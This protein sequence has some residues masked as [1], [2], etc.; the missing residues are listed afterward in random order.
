M[1]RRAML[2]GTIVA[3]W[4]AGLAVLVRR[5]YFRP[6]VE[7]LAEAALRVSPGAVFF[8]VMQ[9][10]QQV[11]FASSTIDTTDGA[12]SVVDY[13]VARTSAGGQTRRVSERTS[14]TLS[15]ALRIRKFELAR[16]ADGRPTRRGGRVE[17]DSVLIFG[18]EVGTEKVDSQHVALS[19]P[20]LLPTLV[21]LAV[22]LGERPKVGKRY[23][24][25]VL[26]PSSM[27]P[28]NVTLRIRAESL[29][30]LNDSSVYDSATTR[31]HGVKPDTVR[32]W[33]LSADATADGAGF[34][35]W[36]DEQGRVVQTT[37]HSFVLQR[38]PYEVAFENWRTDSA[39]TAGTAD[40]RIVEATAI[41]ANKRMD[42]RVTAF[43]VRLSGVRFTAFDLEDAQQ[44]VSGDTV[45]IT[46]PTDSSLSRGVG[47]GS[48]VNPSYGHAEP[49]IQS[50]DP[51]IIALARRLAGPRRSP[52]DIASRLTTW[53]HDSIKPRATPGA[54]SAL[55]VLKKRSGDANEYA[56]LY[57]AL[58]RAAGLP[59][60]IVS[61]VVYIDGTFYYHSWAEVR[62]LDWVAVD[63]TFGLFPADA[64]H[65]RLTVGRLARQT[66]LLGVTGN[67]TIDVLSVSEM[68]VVRPSSNLK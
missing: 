40:D 61:G 38:L 45:T 21:P 48:P 8:G 13:L 67:L 31:W 5:E 12:I 68:P 6:Q 32:A 18:S 28:K 43:R 20:I 14:I 17:G 24:L 55:Q 54:T 2:G 50:D 39:S 22:A 62:L 57:V 49:S 65:L 25:P 51:S 53:V 9:N 16:N 4:I 19:G 52:P 66:E 64:G 27:S 35:G 3:A 33:D 23:I 46:V 44:H 58:A 60:R 63:P 30:V 59:A 47:S 7:R 56:E 1:T 41:E 34:T 29:F 42:R 11:G 15:R 37:Q 10:G 36:V 26:D